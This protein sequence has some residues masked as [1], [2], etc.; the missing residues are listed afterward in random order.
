[1]NEYT[2]IVN[3]KKYII[4]INKRNNK[5][6]DQKPKHLLG[7]EEDASEACLNAIHRMDHPFSGS[8]ICSCTFLSG[9][10]EIYGHFQ[11]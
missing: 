9:S 1:M 2:A 10:V 7:P 6:D 4:K 8:N 3:D 11:L 5:G